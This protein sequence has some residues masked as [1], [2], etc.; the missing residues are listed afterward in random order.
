MSSADMFLELTRVG[1]ITRLHTM[2]D[3]LHPHR[4]VRNPVAA[5]AIAGLR[6]PTL[7]EVFAAAVAAR[8]ATNDYTDQML[9]AERDN[10][11]KE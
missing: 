4:K 3:D 9:A 8:N 10:Q 5:A 2:P 1:E 6:N 7:P 11:K